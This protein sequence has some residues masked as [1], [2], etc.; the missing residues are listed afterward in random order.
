MADGWD[1]GLW[2]VNDLNP[3]GDGSKTLSEEAPNTTRYGG[4]PL[5]GQKM[6]IRRHPRKQV[7]QRLFSWRRVQCPRKVLKMNIIPFR[8]K[9]KE[10]ILQSKM[11]A[12]SAWNLPA[13]TDSSCAAKHYRVWEV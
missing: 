5:L 12:K 2:F 1:V 11:L 9:S 10:R 3:T 13:R 6:A 7:V 8:Q 4:R